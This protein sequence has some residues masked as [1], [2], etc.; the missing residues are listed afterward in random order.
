L[1][2]KFYQITQNFVKIFKN[3]RIPSSLVEKVGVKAI[4]VAV[5]VN[6]NQTL[7]DCLKNYDL[8]LYQHSCTNATKSP[9]TITASLTQII[10]YYF[11]LINTPF[12]AAK[13]SF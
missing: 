10:Q 4:V 7:A 2:S 3:N 9:P 11:I 6:S 1:F 5:V 12:F 13:I 8:V